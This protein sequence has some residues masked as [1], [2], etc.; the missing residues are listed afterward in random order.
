MTKIKYLV[1]GMISGT[2]RRGLPHKVRADDSPRS[3]GKSLH[4]LTSFR[5]FR[6]KTVKLPSHQT[7]TGAESRVGDDDDDDDDDRDD[8]FHH[9]W[10]SFSYIYRLNNA[11]ANNVKHWNSDIVKMTIF[12]SSAES[13]RRVVWWF[14][15]QGRTGTMISAYLLYKR[16]FST[17]EQAIEFFH[18]KRMKPGTSVSTKCDTLKDFDYY[19]WIELITYISWPVT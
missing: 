11:V 19:Y 14:H 3:C 18:S 10:K 1:V 4:E 6:N 16:M 15:F 13:Q 8:G 2:N 17:P 9:S 7:P 12:L 5:R